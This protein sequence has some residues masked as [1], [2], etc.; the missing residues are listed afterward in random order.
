MALHDLSQMPPKC[1]QLPEVC[2]DRSPVVDLGLSVTARPDGGGNAFDAG[3][4]SRRLENELHHDRPSPPRGRQR[5][6]A[7]Q[8]SPDHHDAL[9]A[10]HRTKEDA[11]QHPLDNGKQDAEPARALGEISK[12]EVELL[13]A[14]EEILN[15]RCRK[16]TVC[17]EKREELPLGFLK[18]RA[19][20]TA[21]STIRLVV[22]H[23]HG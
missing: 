16:L 1:E 13:N 2:H 4:R 19:I 9:E 22:D 7:Q 10:R 5:D 3:P 20:H 18:S 11:I 12:D 17:R 14:W 15:D 21:E 23:S 6:V 8:L